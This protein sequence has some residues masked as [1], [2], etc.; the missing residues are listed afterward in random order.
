[1]HA[2]THSGE[3]AAEVKKGT[4]NGRKGGSRGA[5]V[6]QSSTPARKPTCWGPRSRALFA[7]AGWCACGLSYT[8]QERELPKGSSTLRPGC[9]R[10]EIRI[11]NAVRCRRRKAG[12]QESCRSSIR[13]N[14]LTGST[15]CTTADDCRGL[16]VSKARTNYWRTPTRTL[17]GTK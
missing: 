7:R 17:S 13:T 12:G 4:V 1:M 11:G 15:A 6:P 9:E 8:D 2:L 14:S 10:Q 3:A 5:R 16:S